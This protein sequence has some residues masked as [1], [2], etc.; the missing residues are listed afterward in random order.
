MSKFEMAV[1]M[2]KT[3]LVRDALEHNDNNQ[4]KAAKALGIHRNTL[5]RIARDLGITQE[6]GVVLRSESR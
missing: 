1:K 3:Y 5:G 4:C 6:H 2:Y